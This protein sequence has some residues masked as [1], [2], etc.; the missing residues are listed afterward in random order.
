M[1]RRLILMAVIL[2]GA[3][4][5]ASAQE[6]DT[7]IYEFRP[8]WYLQGAFGYQYTI[9]ETEDALALSYMNA[10]IA[11]GYNFT[12]VWGL[13]LS[14]NGWESRAAYRPGEQAASFGVQKEQWKWYY[15]APALDVTMDLTNLFGGYKYDRIV[16]VG[17]FLG[18]GANIFFKNDEALAA[19]NNLNSYGAYGNELGDEILSLYWDGTKVSPLGHAGLY[20]DFRI[21]DKFRLGLEGQ[22]NMVMDKYNSRYAKNPDW[23]INALVTAKYNFGG[24]YQE[25]KVSKADILPCPP[26]PVPVEVHDT[27]FV[28]SEKE[29]VIDTLAIISAAKNRLGDGTAIL[30]MSDSLRTEIF[31]PISSDKI[32]TTEAVKLRHILDFMRKYPNS[33]VLITGYA[34]KGTGTHKFNQMISEK[35]AKVVKQYLLKQGIAEDRITTR[36]KGDTE[37]PYNQKGDDPVLNRVSICVIE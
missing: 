30:A 15:V 11:V 25:K 33:K 4:A 32:S 7:T 3:L 24:T 26:V 10:Q 27:V 5:S 28:E 6:Q 36:A 34:D 31:F 13:R 8:H 29:V 16:N 18:A 21:T 35:R 23:Y 2:C 22:G 12:P 20:I 17:L 9:G 14:V 1:K 37:Q 19:K